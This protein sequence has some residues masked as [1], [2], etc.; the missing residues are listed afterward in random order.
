MQHPAP[1]PSAGRL[2]TPKHQNHSGPLQDTPDPT[3]GRFGDSNSP[4]QTLCL[5][6]ARHQASCT[7]PW[8]PKVLCIRLVLGTIF[9]SGVNHPPYTPSHATKEMQMNLPLSLLCNCPPNPL[10]ASQSPPFD[11]PQALGTRSGWASVSAQGWPRAVWVK[12]SPPGDRHFFTS[13]FGLQPCSY[14]SY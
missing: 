13:I 9:F 11:A 7:Q 8:A 6:L 10:L 3:L 12:K 4:R 5:E 1:A 14:C 2:S